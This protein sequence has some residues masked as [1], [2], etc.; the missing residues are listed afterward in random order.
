MKI[1]LVGAGS[2]SFGPSTVRDVLMSDLLA[3]HKIELSL[4]DVNG[5]TVEQVRDYAECV[6][7]KLGRTNCAITSTTSLSAALEGASFVV[8]AVEI[9]RDTYWAMDYHIPRRY[10]FKQIYGENGGPG[11]L[12]HAL[13]T[14][15]L[16][17]EIAKAME[18]CCP[19]ALLLN[20]TN[21][22][23]KLCQAATQLTKTQTV[24]LCHGIYMGM[25]QLEFMLE[26][27][28]GQLRTKACGINH[29]TWFQ[30]IVDAETGEDLYPE[31]RERESRAD[32]F[33]D[34]HEMGLS[35]ILFRRFGLYPSPG[36]NHIGE[37]IS[38]A[39]EFYANELHWF[40]DPVDG[41]PWAEGQTP[42]FLYSM[43]QLDSKRPFKPRERSV[44]SLPTD[45]IRFSGEA[46]IPII[47]SL[48]FDSEKDFAAVN[49][50]NRGFI[51]ELPEDLIVEVPAS[52]DGNGLK[53]HS[54]ARLP[55]P[56]NSLIRTQAS[57]QKLLVEAFDQGSKEKL[58]QAILLEPTVDSYRG[59]VMMMEEMLQLQKVL[60]PPLQ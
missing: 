45:E 38:W 53:P 12:F 56:V 14:M 3:Q 49:V 27:K 30:E 16:I 60:L 8:D 34:W 26:R 28:P 37:Y 19:Q 21:P 52:G 18:A 24:G 6:A 40:Y 20:Y 44:P 11:S 9:A 41:H 15:K 23:H 25:H 58:L 32:W 7:Q 50:P 2:R 35:R 1:A 46:A 10:G 43:G 59:A 33:S 39:D 13:R 17:V 29:F 22:L 4:M 51:P 42:E 47:E 55:E 57:I 48:G 36:T 31:L 5:Q 54:M